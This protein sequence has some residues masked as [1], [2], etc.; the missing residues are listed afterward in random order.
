MCKKASLV[1]CCVLM[2]S[3]AAGVANAELAAHWKLD[4]NANDSAGTNNGTTYG[5]AAFTTG[6][7]NQAVSLDGNG[8]YIA[9]STSPFDFENT[10]FSVA[11]WFKTTGSLQ[12]IL[13]EGGYIG[14][15][16]IGDGGN[17]GYGKIKVLLKSNTTN[18]AY[19][20][21]SENTYNNGQWHHVAADYH[22]RYN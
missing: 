8:D 15:W 4:G 5:G 2:L 21:V 9:G 1:I 7:I 19:T 10:T 11:A 6:K 17:Q 18:D 22:N 13:S 14:G 20:A 16:S 3:L 12:V